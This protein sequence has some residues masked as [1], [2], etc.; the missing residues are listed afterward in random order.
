MRVV[1]IFSK[2]GEPEDL[3]TN[4][5]FKPFQNIFTHRRRYVGLYIE[6]MDGAIFKN[7]SKLS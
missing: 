1:R 3:L 7:N 6:K 5:T 2:E 4:L